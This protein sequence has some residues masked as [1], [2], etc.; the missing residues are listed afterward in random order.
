MTTGMEVN[1]TKIYA[2]R[3]NNNNSESHLK[4]VEHIINY[5]DIFYYLGSMIA[6]VWGVKVDVQHRLYKERSVFDR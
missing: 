1:T 5:V 2:M 4:I 6:V 3:I